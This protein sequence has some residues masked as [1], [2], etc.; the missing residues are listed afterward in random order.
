MG[1]YNT[2]YSMIW[3]IDNSSRMKVLDSH[4]V[5]HSG[6]GDDVMKTSCVEN[7]SRWRELRDCIS[8]HSHMTSKCWIRTN[9]WLVND[10]NNDDDIKF[11]LCC[12][13][14]EDVPDEM[15]HLKSVLK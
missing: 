10:D 13:N 2:C 14:P 4:I 11:M 3:L 7:V 6:G 1:R 12:G 15:S 9:Y 5:K 8:F